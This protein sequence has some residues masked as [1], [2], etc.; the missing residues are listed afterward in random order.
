MPGL[1]PPRLTPPRQAG[2]AAF[3]AFQNGIRDRC[4]EPPHQ[5]VMT[6]VGN[7]RMLDE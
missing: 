7:Y 3:E 1:V 4:I 5:D 6:V 2:L